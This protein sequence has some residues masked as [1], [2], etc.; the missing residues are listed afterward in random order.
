M[1][2]SGPYECE[3][4]VGLTRSLQITIL[5]KIVI[6]FDWFVQNAL[7]NFLEGIFRR[8]FFFTTSTNRDTSIAHVLGDF[9][10]T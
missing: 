5:V 4:E 7:K 6:I 2:S 1:K 3:I 9:R 10:T 8:D